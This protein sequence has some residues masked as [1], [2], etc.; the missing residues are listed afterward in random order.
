M[1]RD[2]TVG[3][4]VFIWC[5]TETTQTCRTR[6]PDVA[7]ARYVVGRLA[8]FHGAIQKFGPVILF[9][10]KLHAKTKTRVVMARLASTSCRHCRAGHLACRRGPASCRPMGR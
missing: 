5:G 4:R 6:I 7:L 2:E 10:P 3:N 9:G 1:R 8:R